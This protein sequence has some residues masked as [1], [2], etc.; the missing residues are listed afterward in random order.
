[1]S[2]IP[3]RN[4]KDDD[5]KMIGLWKVGR[6]IGKGSSGRV[7]IA[8]H[9]KTG[10]Y[11]AVKIVSKNA[12]LTSRMSLRSLGDEA[13]RI[14]H[15]IE[16]EIVIMKL[17]EHPNIMRL[18]DVWE[19]STELYLILEYVEGGELF[20]YL[21]NKGKLSSSE[22]LG[23]FQQIITAVHYCH[24]F[25]IAH[26]DLKPENLLLDKDKNIKV[27]DF[28][29]AAWQG[30][31]D[32][33]RTACGSPHYAAPEVIMG[34]AYN[35]AYSDI[36]SCG[37]I[38]F[39]LLAGRLPFDDEDLTSLLEKVKL[40]KYTMPAD[41]DTRAKDL[42]S[43]ML[44]KDVSKRIT[45]PEILE[46]PFYKSQKPKKMD[47]DIPNLDDIARPLANKDAVDQDIFANLRTLWHGTPDD[48]IN[49]SLTNDKPTWEKGVYHLLVIYRAKHLENYDEDEEKLA[50][51]RA[52][53]R[54]DKKGKEQDE[55][56][57][58]LLA[59]LPPRAGPPTPRRAAGSS[60]LAASSSSI[61]GLS[62]MRQLSFL[63]SSLALSAHATPASAAR[64]LHRQLS[65][66]TVSPRDAARTLSPSIPQAMSP[67]PLQVPEMQD[68]NIQR[69][70]HQIVEHLNVMQSAGTGHQSPGH[71]SMRS[72]GAITAP[73]PTPLSLDPRSPSSGKQVNIRTRDPLKSTDT[74][75]MGNSTYLHN[76]TQPLSI[77][78]R[79]PERSSVSSDK[80]NAR[81]APHL[82]IQTSFGSELLETPARK[83]ST[84][85][86]GT[87][88]RVQILEPPTVERARLKKKR[89]S[90][91]S[92]TS[93]ASA[94]S[95]GSFAPPSPP[96]RRW[97]GH[98]FKFKPTVYHLLS[99]EY[100]EDT[101]KAC[102]QMLEEMGVSVAL[103]HAAAEDPTA[104]GS[105]TLTLKCWMDES[106]ELRSGLTPMK[107]VRFRVEVQ[108]PSAIQGMAGY[109]VLLSLV[110]EKGAAT[111]LKLIYN[112][113]RREWD[114][115]SPPTSSP[116][117]SRNPMLGDD[118]RF[119]EIVYAQ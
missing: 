70:F 112:R 102:R 71:D 33:L 96:K 69:F 111:S 90:A 116:M 40:G 57:N 75:G 36:W 95:E 19:T 113:L 60:R 99:V 37:I 54:R 8:R 26:R 5:P 55:D 87:G 100:P 16:R 86:A 4:R 22:A 23:Y 6:T 58:G 68:E 115:D 101:V 91:I 62:Q 18:Y 63:G 31:S 20:D 97:F 21:C 13:D 12:L 67:L 15:S 25:N 81:R 77:R 83:R 114:L 104:P 79:S 85:S 66:S 3:R 105:D 24:R 10:Q 44:Q 92:P 45:I 47:C 84:R 107:G 1:M 29:M 72:P 52:S 11:A 88:K 50:A 35:G 43:R 118:E 7:R 56:Q 61:P 59:S 28:G 103:A 65:F 14:L 94:L 108:R 9:T 74:F 93:P 80:E 119:V 32:L 78:T 34:H 46:H 48:E 82:S 51:R 98:L 2:H 30:K 109:V 76:T 39:A 64:T 49:A 38:L 117:A 42:I 53:K 89:S 110:L 17:I 106:R 27:A 73:P 41:I